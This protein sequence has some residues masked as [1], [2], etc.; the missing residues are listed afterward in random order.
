MFFFERQA[1]AQIY[2]YDHTISRHDALPIAAA[3]LPAPIT[4][5]RPAQGAVAS[6]TR[7]G[8]RQSFGSAAASAASN[9]R[10]S[11]ASASIM[12]FRPRTTSTP[13]RSEEHTSELQSL[14]RR[15]YAVFC[16]KKKKN[17]KHQ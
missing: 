17:Q 14:M 15:S 9:I 1:T 5:V 2:T 7:N 10:R 12:A 4:T 11:S 16:L 8:G 13:R 3:A 6:G